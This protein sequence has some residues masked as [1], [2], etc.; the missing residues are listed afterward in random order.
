MNGAEKRDTHNVIV[1]KNRQSRQQTIYTS[2]TST[3]IYNISTL[4]FLSFCS[5]FKAYFEESATRTARTN[6][7]VF[8][9]N[10]HN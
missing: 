3:R 7:T 10:L 2:S 8:P 9:V 4:V 6:E 5:T 1:K